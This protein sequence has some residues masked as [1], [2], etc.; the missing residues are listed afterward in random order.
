MIARAFLFSVKAG[1]SFLISK[2]YFADIDSLS[3]ENMIADLLSSPISIY[4]LS[5][6]TAIAIYHW[7]QLVL[8]STQNIILS[9]KTSP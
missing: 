9:S 8:F 1:C 3:A 2:C 5:F 7:A 6:R 4:K